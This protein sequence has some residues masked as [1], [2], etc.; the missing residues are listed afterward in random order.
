MTSWPPCWCSPT[1]EMN[2]IYSLLLEKTNMAAHKN[3]LLKIS[4]GGRYLAS[5]RD[6]SLPE[7]GTN[8][9]LNYESKRGLNLLRDF[10]NQKLI[11][12]SRKITPYSG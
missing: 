7:Q 12:N 6:I 2:E 10:R 9:N 11:V 3:A 5:F 8:I 1:N 4:C